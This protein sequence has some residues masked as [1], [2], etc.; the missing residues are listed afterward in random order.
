VI[1]PRLPKRVSANETVRDMN[2]GIV[3]DGTS[4]HTQRNSS[5]SRYR[6]PH[7]IRGT[8]YTPKGAFVVSRGIVDVPDEIGL[9]FGWAPIEYEHRTGGS[10]GTR[11]GDSDTE[12]HQDL[13]R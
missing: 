7:L 8:V 12:S 4:F 3:I 9:M 1:A 2:D 11:S 10:P 5:M 6:H 13:S